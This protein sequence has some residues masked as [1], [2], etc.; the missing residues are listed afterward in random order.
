MLS[1]EYEI[2]L[3]KKLEQLLLLTAFNCFYLLPVTN[4]QNLHFLDMFYLYVVT[5][6]KTVKHHHDIENIS[7]NTMMN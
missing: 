7:Y 3:S 4:L 6:E 1:V 5:Y 2:K